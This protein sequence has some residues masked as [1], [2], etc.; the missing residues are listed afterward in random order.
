MLLSLAVVAAPVVIA[1]VPEQ[2]TF[3]QYIVACDN[4]LQCQAMGL[5]S[6]DGSGIEWIVSVTRRSNRDALPTGGVS[7][8]YSEEGPPK[9]TLKFDG[10]STHHGW[11]KDRQTGS[12]LSSMLRAIAA[13]RLVEVM[14][15]TG[16]VVGT[17][18]TRGASAALRWIDE[19]QKRAG[20]VTA[21]IARGPKPSSAIPTPPPLPTIKQPPRSKSPARKLSAADIEKIQ[22]LADG[23]CDPER[24]EAE[25]YRLDAK[26]SVGIVNCLLGA[27]QGSQLI[28]VIDEKGRW[29]PAPIEQA[30][31]PDEYSEPYDPYFVTSANYGDRERLLFS[32]AKGRGIGDC[33]YS[34]SWAWDGR[35]F[36]LA[37]Y[38]ALHECRGSLPG[39]WIS[40]W[41]TTNDPLP[42]DVAR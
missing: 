7:P 36:R 32:S 24:A 30:E 21:L 22:N 15:G 25:T 34:A 33:G 10:K 9:F 2:K 12:G 3:G 37:S 31:P 23:M 1:P 38:R 29:R 13:A 18:P 4:A 19:R 35:M 26:H 28:V 41:Q 40:R 42:A 6:E 17:V 16:K 20:T 14:D 27:Y 8:A 39:E 11:D 5:P